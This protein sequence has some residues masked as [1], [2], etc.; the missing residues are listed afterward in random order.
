MELSNVTKWA[1]GITAGTA[2]LGT[3]YW[4]GLSISD[5]TVSDI[6]RK[7]KNKAQKEIDKIKEEYYGTVNK[8]HSTLRAASRKVEEEMKQLEEVIH[9]SGI[10]QQYDQLVDLADRKQSQPVKKI[11]AKRIAQ[12]HVAEKN[13]AV[14]RMK[15]IV[16]NKVLDRMIEDYPHFDEMLIETAVTKAYSSAVEDCDSNGIDVVA[17]KK[18]FI[19]LVMDK[20]ETLLSRISEGYAIA[21]E[22]ITEAEV[23]AEEEELADIESAVDEVVSRRGSKSQEAIHLDDDTLKRLAAMLQQQ[24]APQ[25]QQ[26]APAAPATQTQAQAPVKKS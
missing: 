16:V 23:R 3:A 20:A 19:Q 13:I 26:A 15:G 21:D 24:S 11:L 25:T 12:I 5:D 6:E 7:A 9:K 10:Q 4:I 8:G 1:L 22:I 2:V 17:D 14:L 18:G